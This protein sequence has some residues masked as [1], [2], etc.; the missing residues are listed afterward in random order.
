VVVMRAEALGGTPSR[1]SGLIEFEQEDSVLDIIIGISP[2]SVRR[3]SNHEKRC[4]K[5]KMLDLCFELSINT[6][7][8][9][10]VASEC[11]KSWPPN[12]RLLY[13]RIW[14]RNTRNCSWLV[15]RVCRNGNASSCRNNDGCHEDSAAQF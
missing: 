6:R 1:I 5:D 15:A 10:E 2:A 4:K 11:T 13:G 9:I 3:W 7:T 14:N 8:E 12:A